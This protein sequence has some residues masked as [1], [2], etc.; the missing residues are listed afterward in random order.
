MK[1][2]VQNAYGVEALNVQNVP[3]PVPGAGEV[4]VAVRAAGVDRGAWHLVTGRPGAVRLGTGLRRPRRAV[5]GAEVA[6]VVEAVGDGV[7]AFAVGDEVYGT[8][9]SAFAEQAVAPVKTLARKPSTLSFEEA[10]A[11][12]VT[13]VTAL[14]AVHDVG[15]V[16]PGKRVLVLGAGG[17]VGSLA[18][19]L[20][21]GAGAHVTGECSTGKTGFVASLGADEVLDR[22]QGEACDGSRTYDLVVDTAGHR[23]LGVL[24][25]ALT[26]DGVAVIVGGEGGGGPLGGFGRQLRALAVGSLRRP[27]VRALTSLTGTALLDRLRDKAEHDGWHPPVEATYPL[28]DGA[29]ALRRLE[30]GGVCGKLVLTVPP[31]RMG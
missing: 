14:Q 26:P 11:L 15:V 19:L 25:R 8:A 31:A 10:A 22:A 20:A 1:A 5:P 12:G 27:R 16:T 24:R 2:L 30:S 29:Q 28:E 21:R 9:R 13:G 7:T 18:V 17:G 4:L 3:V 23:G 6:G